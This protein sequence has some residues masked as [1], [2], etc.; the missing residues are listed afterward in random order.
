M[1]HAGTTRRPGLGGGGAR[2]ALAVPRVSPRRPQAP[3]SPR[4]R[5]KEKKKTRRGIHGSPA[6]PLDYSGGSGSG[7]STSGSE[8]SAFCSQAEPQ[9]F[10]SAVAAFQLA[11]LA[12]PPRVFVPKSCPR[13]QPRQL[14][15]LFMSIL[16][17]NEIT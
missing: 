9:V 6:L 16:N 17:L 13:G 2:E 12:P 11:A 7:A 10:L 5:R 14:L 15:I 3:P 4:T 1:R 8:D